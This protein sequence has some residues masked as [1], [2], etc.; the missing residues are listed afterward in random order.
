MKEAILQWDGA[1]M[2]P[3]SIEDREAIEEEF[4][5]NQTVTGRFTR[6]GKDFLPSIEQSN[7]LHACFALVSENSDNP[8]HRTK[9]TTKTAC[10]IGI[11]FRDPS[12]VM[13][14]PDG[15]V[16]FFYRSFSFKKLLGK[17]RDVVMDRAFHW[18]ADVLGVTVSELVAEAQSKMHRR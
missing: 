2:V 16:Q 8:Q 13:V 5:R 3:V 4:K 18:C 15:G 17:E 14:R 1:V 12:M 7:L 6:I 9:E 10:K 11:D